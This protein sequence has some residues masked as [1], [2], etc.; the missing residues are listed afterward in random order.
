MLNKGVGAPTGWSKVAGHLVW[1]VKMDF[2]QKA[3]WVLDGHKIPIQLHRRMQ[4]CIKLLVMYNPVSYYFM[5]CL[6]FNPPTF[7]LVLCQQI[8]FLHFYPVLV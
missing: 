5:V 2:T 4:E 3:R 8:L 6:V 7:P 1:D